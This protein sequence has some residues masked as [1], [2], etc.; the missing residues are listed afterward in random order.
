MKPRGIL[1]AIAGLVV[2]LLGLIWF[3]G[4]RTPACT[5]ALTVRV[6]P[7]ELEFAGDPVSVAACHGA[8]CTPAPLTRNDDGGWQLPAGD[9]T[10]PNSGPTS[11]S[12]TTVTVTAGYPEGHT[13]TQTLPVDV[14]NPEACGS[15]SYLRVRVP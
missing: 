2:V 12:P 11:S 10:A 4:T 7:L 15:E 14:V 1:P 5:L 3:A 6:S 13:T 8:G 9:R